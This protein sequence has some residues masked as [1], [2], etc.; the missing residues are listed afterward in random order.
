MLVPQSVRRG[1]GIGAKVVSMRLMSTSQ[2]ADGVVGCSS[3][4]VG[5]EVGLEPGVDV[6]D[7]VDDARGGG[8]GF[9]FDLEVAE[10]YFVVDAVGA[11]AADD[12]VGVVGE[13]AGKLVGSKLDTLGDEGA[14][15]VYAVNGVVVA[16]PLEGLGGGA[17]VAVEAQAVDPAC[18][19]DQGAVFG[20]SGFVRPSGAVGDGFKVGVGSSQRHV[21]VGRGSAKSGVDYCGHGQ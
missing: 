13:G 8:A 10:F 6:E 14:G 16:G 19:G 7:V 12:G 2:Q 4:A 1:P 21:A 17:A 5:A 3:W 11:G 9:V 15:E 20:V 18:G